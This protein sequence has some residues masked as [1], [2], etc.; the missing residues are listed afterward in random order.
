MTNDEILLFLSQQIEFLVQEEDYGRA[1]ELDF[2]LWNWSGAY[3]PIKDKAGKFPFQY[4][5]IRVTTMLLYLNA[6]S[7]LYLKTMNTREFHR[8]IN[9]FECIGN[10]KYLSEAITIP[11]SLMKIDFYLNQGRLYITKPLLQS[12]TKQVKSKKFL[13]EI[14]ARLYTASHYG[15][16]VLMGYV[17]DISYLTTALGYAEEVK[18]WKLV[19]NLYLQMGDAFQGTYPALAVSMSWQA[20]VAAERHHDKEQAIRARLQRSFFEIMMLFKYNTREK[21]VN[22]FKDDAE[23]IV[24]SI[25]RDDISSEGMRTNYD[26]TRGFVL[27]DDEALYRAL[28][29]YEEYQIYPMVYNLSEQLAE[30]ALMAHNKEKVLSLVHKQLAAAKKMGDPTLIKRATKFLEDY[31]IR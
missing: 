11:H 24:N 31:E 18:D 26:V 25:S 27:G 8:S 14:Y 5:D 28:T 15:G 7:V 19:S 4:K 13:A 22:F 23:K 20:E 2:R 10:G 17:P 3:C 1:K 6:R 29:Y 12:L 30:K 21:N 16:P 9:T